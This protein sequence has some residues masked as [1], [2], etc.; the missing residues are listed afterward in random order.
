M[1]TKHTFCGDPGH[2]PTENTFGGDPD[3]CP[4]ENTFGG[5]PGF[6][7][8]KTYVLR[9]PWFDAVVFGNGGKRVF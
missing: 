3:L 1:P 5:D 9:G 2:Y 6:M 8:H 7:P 4:T